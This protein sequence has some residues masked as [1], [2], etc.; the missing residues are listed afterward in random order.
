[1]SASSAAGGI[2]AG[3]A[4]APAA[5]NTVVVDV[6]DKLRNAGA[7]FFFHSIEAGGA[8]LFWHRAKLP[9]EGAELRQLRRQILEQGWLQSGATWQLLVLLPLASVGGGGGAQNALARAFGGPPTQAESVLAVRERLLAPL[10][11]LECAPARTVLIFVDAVARYN[12]SPLPVDKRDGQRYYLDAQGYVSDASGISASG[13]LPSPLFGEADFRIFTSAP[14]GHEKEKLQTWQREMVNQLK[15]NVEG[16]KRDCADDAASLYRSHWRLDELLERFHGKLPNA[17]AEESARQRSAALPKIMLDGVPRQVLEGALRELYSVASLMQ[18]MPDGGSCNMVVLRC[19]LLAV[20]DDASAQGARERYKLAALTLMFIE[21]GRDGGAFQRLTTDG[22]NL[23]M[24]AEVTFRHD[25]QDVQAALA[26]YAAWLASAEE[27]GQS[28][29]HTL[30]WVEDTHPAPANR[31]WPGIGGRQDAA[32]QSCQG[33]IQSIRA[34][35]DPKGLE[36]YWHAAVGGGWEALCAFQRELEDELARYRQIPLM[37]PNATKDLEETA[38]REALG[39][40]VGAG[41]GAAA[42][43]S[44]EGGSTR[45]QPGAAQQLRLVQPA[46]E[47]RMERAASEGKKLLAADAESLQTA[48][49]ASPYPAFTAQKDWQ[50]K[51]ADHLKDVRRFLGTL[52][53]PWV[54]P[55][56]A[57]AALFLLACPYAVTLYMEGK[58]SAF[59]L[60]KTWQ[61]VL[62]VAFLVFTPWCITWFIDWKEKKRL[63]GALHDL[64]DTVGIRLAGIFSG[65]V[66]FIRKLRRCLLDAIN[67]SACAEKLDGF[68]ERHSKREY[69]SKELETRMA[70]AGQLAGGVRPAASAVRAGQTLALNL[71]CPAWRQG[72]LGPDREDDRVAIKLKGAPLSRSSRRIAGVAE[73]VCREDFV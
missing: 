58:W 32:A 8:C 62:A 72:S 35:S 27:K 6:A 61:A 2:V 59:Q 14:A 17:I 56:L 67:A 37:P 66:E 68:T 5:M 3:G 33:A 55:M 65:G 41:Q 25:G 38:F 18:D 50:Q 51:S 70:W 28:Q 43:P 44:V 69:F 19:P 46:A 16:K 24:A 30:A 54:R 9:Q 13:S 26:S 47:Q 31:P 21:N 60:A 36:G 42:T 20:N 15:K 10:Q 71:D 52:P 48:L 39:R 34:S 22:N 7:R 64:I 63:L 45:Q 1:M 49:A 12:D 57:G 73:I 40:H 29:Q 53:R 4:Q 11:Q 23:P